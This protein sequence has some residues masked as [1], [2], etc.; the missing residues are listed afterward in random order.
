MKNLLGILILT[1]IFGIKFIQE[2]DN[3]YERAQDFNIF[4]VDSVEFWG[5]VCYNRFILKL[6]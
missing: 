2:N 4:L 6:R 5:L 1:Q 3:K